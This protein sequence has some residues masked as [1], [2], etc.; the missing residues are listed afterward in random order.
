[1]RSSDGEIDLYPS[2]L[3]LLSRVSPGS[4]TPPW[5]LG[6]GVISSDCVGLRNRATV[7]H[8]LDENLWVK[9]ARVYR[10]DYRTT[11]LV[12][13]EKPL[14]YGGSASTRGGFVEGAVRG[15]PDFLG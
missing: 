13:M 12:V 11:P 15:S 9:G 3:E 7:A 10:L 2:L 6:T 8:W 4:C 5:K 14:G 1:M